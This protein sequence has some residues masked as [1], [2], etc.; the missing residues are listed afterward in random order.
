MK[1]LLGLILS[2]GLLAGC[3]TTGVEGQSTVEVVEL[4]PLF[5]PEV[6]QDDHLVG[7]N[8]NIGALRGPTGIGLAQLMARSEDG[9]T[10][11]NYNF[12]LGGAPEEM[13]AGLI[14]G[15]L[16]IATVPVNVASVLY[17][18]TDG[19]VRMIAVNT[20]GV[21]FVLDATGEI[22]TIS[23]LEGRTINA[24]GQ[25]A[26]PQFALEHILNENGINATIVYNTEH[27]ELASLMIA[28]NVELGVLPQPFVTTVTMQNPDINVAL[29]LTAEWEAVNSGSA[30]VQGA[31]VARQSFIEENPDAIVLFLQDQAESVAFVTNNVEEASQL[32]GRFDIIPP[33][34][35]LQAIPRSNLV[36]IIGDD[37]RPLVN[38]FL[39]VVYNANP[40][41]VG[42][43]LP[44]E[45]FF[46]VAE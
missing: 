37:M 2:L 17:N 27:T 10:V 31:I 4:P 8:I 34:V 6:P 20:L 41:A 44:D 16:D 1:Y 18:M 15:S 42:G 39:E 24:T 23:D 9:L 21:L 5:E 45:N 12:T 35:A 25:G 7:A 36:H 11:N 28:G 32:T 19:D 26:T 29:D 14:N 13:T 38:S 3:A 43:S 22:E 40:Q 46:F 30:F 33:P